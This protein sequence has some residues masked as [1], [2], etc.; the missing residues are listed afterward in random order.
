M[1][2]LLGN[3]PFSGHQ[4]FVRIPD[5]WPSAGVKTPAYT[6]TMPILLSLGSLMEGLAQPL[7]IPTHA[8]RIQYGR[9]ILTHHRSLA[10]H[11]VRKGE[12]VWMV[13]KGLFGEADTEMED[14]SHL[15]GSPAATPHRPAQTHHSKFTF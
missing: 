12:T 7:S 14:D 3:P 5:T 8:F 9:K 15:A 6:L 11:G 10:A 1:A 2:N 4:V 13:I